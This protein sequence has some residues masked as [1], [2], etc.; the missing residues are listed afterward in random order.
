MVGVSC[1]YFF[2]LFYDNFMEIEGMSL[3]GEHLGIDCIFLMYVSLI[4]CI[5]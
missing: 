1:D 4:V 2:S 3:G 5:L